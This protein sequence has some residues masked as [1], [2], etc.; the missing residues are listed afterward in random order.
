MED[1][2]RLARRDRNDA[3]ARRVDLGRRSDVSASKRSGAEID[4]D[5][6]TRGLTT[7][8]RR[9]KRESGRRTGAPKV[10]PGASGT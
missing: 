3:D 4:F 5:T 7:T 6:A 1:V 2:A 8:A 9:I 10:L